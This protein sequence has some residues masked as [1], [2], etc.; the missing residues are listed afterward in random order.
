MRYAVVLAAGVALA[1]CHVER[2]DHDANSSDDNVMISGAENGTVSFNVPFA[3]GEVNL[4]SSAMAHGN[5]DIDGVKLYPG[6]RMHGF[7]V[8]ATNGKSQVN[9][10]FTAPAAPDTV[11]DYFIDEFKKSGVDA[12]ASGDA[13]TGKS[14]D[15]NQF[16]IDLK[17]AQNGTKGTI[18]IDGDDDDK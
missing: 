15:G 10:A 3:K 4:P 5:F 16:A 1:G 6:S 8:E 13:I 11:R 9:M 2:K 17:P 7:H 12:S 14:K 18:R